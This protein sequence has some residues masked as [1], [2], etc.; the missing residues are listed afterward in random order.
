MG[1]EGPWTADSEEGRGWRGHWPWPCLG[2][3]SPPRSCSTLFSP[4]YPLPFPPPPSL[5]CCRP[6]DPA[7]LTTMLFL[8]CVVA[9]L[10]ANIHG[11]FASRRAHGAAIG[12]RQFLESVE[13]DAVSTAAAA[14]LPVS[15]SE[16]RQYVYTPADLC[17]RLQTQLLKV[18]LYSRGAGQHD[19]SPC[20][21]HWFCRSLDYFIGVPRCRRPSV[22][23][24]L[25]QFDVHTGE[26]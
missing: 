19:I 9:F 15:I 22:S 1:K 16:D 6:G 23:V 3:A 8:C 14:M 7:V 26:R 24:R 21:R 12:V 20:T 4:T 5:L 2:P 11:T 13:A 10:L 17:E 18:L 25:R